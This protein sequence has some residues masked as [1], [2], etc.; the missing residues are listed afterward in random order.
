M[1]E[2][3]YEVRFPLK[4]IGYGG[5]ALG[6]IALTIL[7]PDQEDKPTSKYCTVRTSYV[8]KFKHLAD[9]QCRKRQALNA[10]AKTTIHSGR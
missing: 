10:E 6:A 4:T 8:R 3:A 5:S 2:G 7:S 9:L 1:M